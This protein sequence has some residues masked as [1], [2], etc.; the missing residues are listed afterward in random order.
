MKLIYIALLTLSLTSC[1]Y[2]TDYLLK[3]EDGV[4]VDAQIGGNENKVKTGL[5]SLGNKTNNTISVEDSNQVAVDN[6]NGR[7]HITTT[8]GDPTINVYE[9]NRWLYAIFGLYIIGK[10][11]LRW[12]WDRKK[13]LHPHEYITYT[14]ITPD[15][16]SDRNI[17]NEGRSSK[18]NTDRSSIYIQ[19]LRRMYDKI[20]FT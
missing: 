7:Y 3:D 13:K 10:P 12:Y 4:N 1:S 20:K 19:V 9:T 2:V 14:S 17:H 11:A 8:T 16:G 6:T 18:G 5:G 15:T